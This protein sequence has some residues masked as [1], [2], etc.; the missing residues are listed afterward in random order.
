MQELSY[1][2]QEDIDSHKD[3]RLNIIDE[4]SFAGYHTVLLGTSHFLQKATE[5]NEFQ[6]GRAA[7]CFLGDFCQLETI[8]KDVIY[9]QVDGIYWEQ[10]LNC[11]VELKGTHRYNNCPVLQQIMPKTRNEGLSQ[12][13]RKIL[14][15]RVIDGIKVKMP[16]PEKTRFATFFNAKRCGINIDVFRRYLEKHHTD[17]TPGNIPESAIVIKSK[18]C[19]GKSKVPLSFEQRKVFFEK[20]SEAM[21][22]NSRSKHL[23]PILCLGPRWN[24]MINDNIDVHEGIANGTTAEFVKAYLKAGAKLV[25][26]QMFGYWVNSVTVEEVDQLEFEWQDYDRFKGTFRVDPTRGVY[27]VNFPVTEFGKEIRVPTTMD[28][29]QFPSVGNFATTGHKLQGKSVNELVIAEWSKVK[30]W[31]YVVLSRVRTL[32]GLFLEKPI[33]ADIDFTPNPDYLAMMERMRTSILVNPIDTDQ[34][35]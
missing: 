16:R 29:T 26:I 15:S 9:K 7:M 23:D 6:Y 22:T 18:A 34:W 30:N 8:D 35:N 32:A 1:A 19:W 4:V 13:D 14:N 10:S 12:A 27:K 2:T 33:P 3:T 25:P 5:C 11:L 21:V 20:C 24:M 31:A 17:C 28:I